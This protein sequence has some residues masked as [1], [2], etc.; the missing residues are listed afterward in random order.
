MGRGGKS[1]K[2]YTRLSRHDVTGVIMADVTGTTETKRA[3]KKAEWDS[4]RAHRAQ[5][6]AEK[7]LG[8]GPSERTRAGYPSKGKP[9][10]F[11][12]EV[13]KAALDPARFLPALIEKASASDRL[14]TIKL[15][16]N[17]YDYGMANTKEKGHTAVYKAHGETTKT[18]N[19]TQRSVF[20]Q[21][22]STQIGKLKMKQ[23]EFRT[24]LKSAFISEA[25]KRLAEIRTDRGSLGKTNAS[26]KVDQ[27]VKKA[28]KKYGE[29]E[30]T[31]EWLARE[32]TKVYG[33]KS[34]SIGGKTRK[35]IQ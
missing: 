20:S 11:E 14:K 32:I 1:K 28:H 23:D 34:L 17:I 7:N 33:Q 22:S 3:A 24:V 18:S 5:V 26:K 16:G 2:N 4:L 31:T 15:L 19:Y 30:T 8:M 35:I 29:K 27:I 6:D 21:L 10:K 12:T 13:A 9:T 25:K